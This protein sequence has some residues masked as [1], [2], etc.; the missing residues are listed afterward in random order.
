VL[1]AILC[2]FGLKTPIHAPNK[3]SP[4]KCGGLRRRTAYVARPRQW[5]ASWTG[6]TPANQVRRRTDDSSY[7]MPERGAY[8][9]LSRKYWFIGLKWR[10]CRVRLMSTA[11][12]AKRCSV[13]TQAINRPTSVTVTN[14]K[15]DLYRWL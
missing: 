9:G 8:A 2:W 15:I 4:Y 3:A 7:V 10:W 1:I 14:I 5:A 13:R 12:E 6:L 11:Y